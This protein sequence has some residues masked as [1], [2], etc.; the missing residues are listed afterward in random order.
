MRDAGVSVM[1]STIFRLADGL[2]G[3]PI[4]PVAPAPASGIASR[5]PPAPQKDSPEGAVFIDDLYCAFAAGAGLELPMSTT[6]FQE[7]RKS[8]V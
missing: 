2:T 4:A 8:V 5:F 7:D 1:E 3:R 6:I